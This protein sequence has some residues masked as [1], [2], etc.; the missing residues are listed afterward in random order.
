MSGHWTFAKTLLTRCGAGALGHPV[1]PGALVYA[2]A[3]EKILRCVDHAPAH[4]LDDTTAMERASLEAES[5]H[6]SQTAAADT[7]T[8]SSSTA[9]SNGRPA[10][11]P[12]KSLRT[13]DFASFGQTVAHPRMRQVL[14]KRG[15][16][17]TA[18]KKPQPFAKVA[19]VPDP[20][21]DAFSK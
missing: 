10:R 18:V 17:T 13:G 7:P 19:D 8:P 9:L 16:R 2:M 12:A 15:L 4:A 21:A 14:E 1:A 11:P 20:K 5:H 3:N 6:T